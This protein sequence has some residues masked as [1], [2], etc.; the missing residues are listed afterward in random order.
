MCSDLLILPL[1]LLDNCEL[2]PQRCYIP[3]QLDWTGTWCKLL[4]DDGSYVVARPAQRAAAETCCFVDTVVAS[5]GFMAN[6]QRLCRLESL[7]LATNVVQWVACTVS[8][9]ERLLQR[10]QLALEQLQQD[11]RIFLRHLKL[12]KGCAVQHARLLELGI[13]SIEISEVQGMDLTCRSCFQLTHETPLRIL[14]VRLATATCL[15]RLERYQPYG[16]E[17][18]LQALEQLLRSAQRAE[19]RGLPLNALLVGA[20]GSGKSC[21]LAEFLRRHSCNCFHITASQVLRAQPG[22]TES[23]LRRIFQAAHTFQQRLR[24]QRPVVILLEDLELLCP[25][26]SSADARNSGNAMRIAAQ[27]YRLIDELPQRH[28][29]ILCLASSGSPDAVHPHARRA[30]R[31]GHEL[32]IDMPTEQQRRQLFA[33]LWQQ[34]QP[35]HLELLTPGLLD[36]LAQQTQGYVIADLTLLLRQLQQ[37]M[38]HLHPATAHDF[39]RLLKQSLLQCQPSASRATDVRILKLAA[40]FESIGGMAALKRTL[41][42]SVLAALQH[43]E[44]HARFGLS[45]PR[46]LLLYGPPGCAKTTIAKCLAKEAHMTFIATSAAEVYSPYVGC[47]ERF[48]TQIFNTARKNAP[49]LIFLDEIDSLVGRRTVG[50]GSGNSSVQLRILSTLLTEMDGI[51]SAG[52]GSSLQHILVVAATNRPDMLDDALLRP[53]RFDKLIHV[54]APDLASRLAL[55]QLHARRMPFHA[56]VQLSE[57]AARTESYSGADLCNLCNEAAIE[58]FQRDFDVTHIE[59]QDFETVL[60]RQKSSLSQ[61]QIESYYKFAARY[62]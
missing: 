59:T 34:E 11:V 33:G 29:G 36:Y 18:P 49:C 21:L 25:A 24:P 7:T 12:I 44:A 30:G 56:N 52:S 10:P 55:L 14:D 20:V 16:F 26:T 37:Q 3:E 32:T 28:G 5:P 8:I 38:L 1:D 50:S 2:E 47:A 53:G 13:A 45:L 58:A 15:P 41:Q 27:L 35:T 40:G 61:Q 51:V 22:E 6:K 42:V 46:G 23:E 4:L 39:E 60:A 57:L 48:I 54:P 62:L 17:A 31:F 43:S 19:F 9:T